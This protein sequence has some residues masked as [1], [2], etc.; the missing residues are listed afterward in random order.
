MKQ[1]KKCPFLSAFDGSETIGFDSFTTVEMAC[2]ALFFF[3]L[4]AIE[5]QILFIFLLKFPRD[6]AIRM[7]DDS[8][9]AVHWLEADLFLDTFESLTTLLIIWGI[10]TTTN[11]K[12]I[13]LDMAERKTNALQREISSVLLFVCARRVAELLCYFKKWYKGFYICW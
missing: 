10:A 11:M 12:T 2:L 1:N 13:R 8:N 4:L 9:L 6:W 7:F 3:F 5:C